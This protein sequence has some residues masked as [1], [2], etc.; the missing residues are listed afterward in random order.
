M[1]SYERCSEAAQRCLAQLEAASNRHDLDVV[2][3][4]WVLVRTQQRQQD[5]AGGES[6]LRRII[7]IVLARDR[8]V[9]RS[10]QLSVRAL[11]A[12]SCLDDLYECCGMN[13]QRDALHME[14]PS[15][16]EL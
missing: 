10:S 14:F 2:K 1:G 12:I 13:E 11:E 5:F 4:L 7:E 16:F 9:L 3:T 6:S 15:A 8:R